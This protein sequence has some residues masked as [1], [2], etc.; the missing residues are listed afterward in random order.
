MQNLQYNPWLIHL[1][2][3]LLA[4]DQYSPVNAV[5]SKEGNPFPDAPPRFI[6]AD[7]YRYK[8]TR[9]G[10]GDKNW[11][12]RSNQRAYSPILELKGSQLRPILRQMNWK[13]P[14]IPMRS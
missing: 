11:W 10:S 2:I 4:S 5:L 1:M 13:I 9:I 3:H 8:F 6:K 12:T 14:T 7:L